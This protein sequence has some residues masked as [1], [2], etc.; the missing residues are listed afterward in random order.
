MLVDDIEKPAPAEDSA[1]SEQVSNYVDYVNRDDI[2]GRL[3]RDL[4]GLDI[5]PMYHVKTAKGQDVDICVYSSGNIDRP[6]QYLSPRTMMEVY[7][8]AF[9]ATS[10]RLLGHRYLMVEKPREEPNV[11]GSIAVRDRDKSLS[12]VLEV[13][14][15]DYLQRLADYANVPIVQEVTNGVKIEINR[16]LDA[17]A[18]TEE[19][20][21]RN[22]F[23]QRLAQHNAELAR[24]NSVYGDGGRLGFD[25]YGHKRFEPAAK[26][27]VPIDVGE[28]F[29]EV[30]M[31]TDQS[32]RSLLIPDV[33]DVIR[34]SLPNLRDIRLDLLRN[35]ILPEFKSLHSK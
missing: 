4:D 17:E 1:S 19:D 6:E 24:W 27:P 20:I 29:L 9:D 10:K 31:V 14:S 11:M 8:V 3:T 18:L 25:E 12:T 23:R 16:L 32:G 22:H 21:I 15:H 30:R 28:I 33:V 34:S 2:E 35:V 13:V 7:F 26:K 5:G